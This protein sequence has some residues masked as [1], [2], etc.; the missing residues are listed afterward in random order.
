MDFHC[1]Y[2]TV[3]GAGPDDDGFEY[4]RPT[5]ATQSVW[6]PDLQH[7]GPPSGLMVRSL[8]RHSPDPGAQFTR[9][10]TDI[11]GA[12][13]FGINRVRTRVVRPGRQICLLTTELEVQQPDGSYRPVGRTSAWR[14][15]I[16]DTAAAV[17][18]PREPLPAP[19]TL[20]TGPGVR[21]HDAGVDWGSS[22]FLGTVVAANLPSVNGATDAYW[23]RPALPLV[24]GEHTSDIESIF[25][26]LDIANGVGTTL[27]PD[28]WSWMNTDTTVHLTHEP[29]GPWIG[30]DAETSI[31]T[32]GYGATFADLFDVGGFLGRSAQTV[33][34]VRR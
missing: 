21:A 15:R 4:F 14:M 3:G 23:I 34:L 5:G 25:T 24:A 8:T 2:E 13:G 10:T 20:D 17:H 1:Y 16:A 6:S 27:Q 32:A 11:L 18:S 12:I 22:G 31:G 7:G 19:E 26:V 33:L 30:I 9:I 28:V 29:T